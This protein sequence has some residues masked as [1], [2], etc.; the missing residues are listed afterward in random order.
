MTFGN[1]DSWPSFQNSGRN[2]F[3]VMRRIQRTA[4]E[5]LT[6]GNTQK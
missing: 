6:P 1:G 4:R 2:E 5:I 3:V